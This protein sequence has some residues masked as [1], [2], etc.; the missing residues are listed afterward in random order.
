MA[1]G[2]CQECIQ[3]FPIR[4]NH[5]SPNAIKAIGTECKQ[6]MELIDSCIPE[7]AYKGL[8]IGNYQRSTMSYAKSMW[9]ST[10]ATTYLTVIVL[11]RMAVLSSKM[12]A[13]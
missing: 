7:K 4:L 12:G 10:R 6:K 11:T 8:F 2:E 13:W 9:G 1:N 5:K 3:I